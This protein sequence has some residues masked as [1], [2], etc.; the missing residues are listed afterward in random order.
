MGLLL[1]TLFGAVHDAFLNSELPMRL[2]PLRATLPAPARL[3]PALIAPALLASAL[4]A[5]CASYGP[6]SVQPGQ[7]LDA[8]V[9]QLGEPT[10]RYALPD[11][12][13]R[14][15]YARGPFGKHT[16]MVDVDASGRVTGWKQ[17]LTE[18]NFNAVQP[19]M[20]QDELLARLGRPSER[21]P[22]GWQGGQVWS[23]RYDAVFCQ[24]FQVSVEEGRVRDAAY[25]PD[26]LCDH[27][28]NDRG[29]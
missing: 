28:D 20:T 15:E 18:G 2:P 29:L 8:V 12:T 24:W 27:G 7:S 17:V 10:G 3:A 11:G 22:G 25:A 9:A 21:Q 4:V 23:Y 16:W 14:F 5:G 13:T 6:P 1:V 19:G 26:P